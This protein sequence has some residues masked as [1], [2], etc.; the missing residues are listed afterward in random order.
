VEYDAC[1]ELFAFGL[2]ERFDVREILGMSAARRIRLERVAGG[3]ARVQ[4]ELGGLAGFLSPLDS[5]V[6][7]GP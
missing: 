5:A 3:L 6:K 1:P 7:I 4:E 2:L